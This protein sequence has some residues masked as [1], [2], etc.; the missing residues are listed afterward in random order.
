MRILERSRI[1]SRLNG[2]GLGKLGMCIGVSGILHFELASLR[3]E[4]LACVTVERHS[5]QFEDLLMRDFDADFDTRLSDQTCSAS[6]ADQAM[7]FVYCQ[8]SW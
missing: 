4:P 5:D 1:D 2:P 3:V 8:N 6:S 7:C